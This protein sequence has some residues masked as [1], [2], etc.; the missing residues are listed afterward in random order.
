M[1]SQFT[2]GYKDHGTEIETLQHFLVLVISQDDR[3]Q[4]YLLE[5]MS[6]KSGGN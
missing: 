6:Q 3:P 1:K 2:T 4:S 5:E